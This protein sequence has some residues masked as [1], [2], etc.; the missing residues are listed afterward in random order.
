MKTLWA[1]EP[2]HQDNK[3]IVG[4]H[5]M[6]TQ[7]I[8]KK[9]EVQVGF[10]VTRKENELALAFDI[11]MKDRFTSYPR[12][13]IKNILAK[14]KIKIKDKDIFVEDFETF[15]T[16]KAVDHMLALAKKNGS[17]LLAL[18]THSRRGFARFTLGSFAE[19]AI[20]NSKIN[21][22][23]AGPNTNFP[24]KI[25]NIFYSSDFSPEGK[26]HLKQV[27]EL[28]SSTGAKLTVFHAPKLTYKWVKNETDL[29]TQNYRNQVNK[30]SKD[31]ENDCKKAGVECNV[32]LGTEIKP[33]SELALKVAK[34]SKADLMVVSA[35]TGKVGALMGG[36]ITRQ[37]VRGSEK[38]VLVLK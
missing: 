28:A 7:I 18:Y 26:N 23:L 2:F 31:I 22:L 36:S 29:D 14:A 15:S 24:T 38:P 4:M 37:L 3:R 33:I 13:L 1:L 20:H 21:L 8:G 32:I 16:T 34:K 10:V 27:I 35:K 9:S 25:K 5:T 11:P 12:K 19:T 30:I 6:L 17:E